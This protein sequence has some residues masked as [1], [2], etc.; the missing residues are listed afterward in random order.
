VAELPE[1]LRGAPTG[2]ARV[3][4]EVLESHQRERVI[5]LVVPVFAKRGFQG[6]TVDDLLASGKVGVGNFY[7]LFESKEDCFLAAL[8]HVV[9]DARTQ[10]AAA[11]RRG[12]D[13]AESA[14]LGLAALI[15]LI[16]AD[17]FAARL[18]LV[19]AQS[20]GPAALARHD[21]ILAEAVEWLAEGRARNPAAGLLPSFE[22]TT[23]TGLAYYLQ[24]CLLDPAEHGASELLGEISGLMLEPLVGAARMSRLRRAGAATPA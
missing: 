14:Y 17:R 16:L 3:P 1:H 10:I 24:H 12:G 11:A 13:W 5:A 7:E 18:V 21:A 23:V 22:Q 15:E 20:A 2:T 8:D 9:A 6:A 4:R 19:E